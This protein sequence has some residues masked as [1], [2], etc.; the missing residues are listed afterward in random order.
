MHITYLIS[1]YI[2]T[3]TGSQGKKTERRSCIYIDTILHID[4]LR[5]II[6]QVTRTGNAF[7]RIERKIVSDET[8]QFEM[9]LQMLFYWSAI[10]FLCLIPCKGRD[11]KKKSKENRYTFFH[12]NLFRFP[13]KPG[14]TFK[15]L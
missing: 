15:I 3:K 5:K 11:S 4:I 7:T 14:M 12:Y 9:V 2:H 6:E 8:I 10:G 13:V 1:A